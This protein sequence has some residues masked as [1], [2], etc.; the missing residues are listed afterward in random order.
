VQHFRPHVGSPSFDLD[1]KSSTYRVTNW[2]PPVLAT[3]N[4][5]VVG[6]S[7]AEALVALATQFHSPDGGPDGV[8]RVYSGLDYVVYYSASD[9]RLAPNIRG[10]RGTLQGAQHQPTFE[11]GVVGSGLDAD[12][13]RGRPATPAPDIV[14][15]LVTYTDGQGGWK[16]LDL[17]RGASG[18]WANSLPG[19]SNSPLTY[20]VQAV[21][22]NSNVGQADNKG[23]FY[24]LAP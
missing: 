10:V 17:A 2:S 12:P 13:E 5:L 24:T 4:R 7:V 14:R 16:T 21:D 3:V 18:Q 1:H 9:L 19:P 15:V 8:A 11:V 22:A 23:R 20:F 6:D